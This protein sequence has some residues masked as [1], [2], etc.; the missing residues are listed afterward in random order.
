MKGFLH[1][2]SDLAVAS[3]PCAK[4]VM[5]PLLCGVYGNTQGL[6]FQA[7]EN[8][9]KPRFWLVLSYPVVFMVVAF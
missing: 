8:S 4:D 3:K 2:G 1:F 7:A 6:P 9:S 5:S